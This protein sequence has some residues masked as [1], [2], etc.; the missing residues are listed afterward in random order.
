MSLA[1][2]SRALAEAA[3]RD[4]KAMKT[5]AV[6]TMLYLPPTAIA[7]IFAM[8]FFQ[9]EAKAS[10]PLVSGRFWI[11]WITAIPLTALTLATWFVW[12]RRED[13]IKEAMHRLAKNLERVDS[14]SGSIKV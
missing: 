1:A 3:T 14:K 13:N 11:Y 10:E 4:A 7:T 12:V 5:L 8:P 9:W 2:D 6:V